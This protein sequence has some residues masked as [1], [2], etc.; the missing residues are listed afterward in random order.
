MAFT[1]PCKNGDTCTFAHGKDDLRASGGGAGATGG[2]DVSEAA[3]KYK[4]NLC[5]Q[6]VT[7]GFC[8]YGDVCHFAHGGHE[9][10]PSQGG[11]GAAPESQSL[12]PNYKKV[13]CKNYSQVRLYVCTLYM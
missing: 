1:G 6:F 3:A 10:R 9:L 4:T 8:P 11:S 7:A 2:K 5:K 13:L 12:S